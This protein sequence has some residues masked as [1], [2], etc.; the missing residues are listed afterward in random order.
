MRELQFAGYREGPYPSDAVDADFGQGRIR[1]R[2]TANNLFSVPGGDCHALYHHAGSGYFLAVIGDK[3]YRLA[4]GSSTQLVSGITPPAQVVQHGSKLVLVASNKVA[5]INPDDWSVK[6]VNRPSAPSNPSASKFTWQQGD[7]TNVNNAGGATVTVNTYTIGIDDNTTDALGGAWAEL[8]RTDA[9][10]DYVAYLVL[11][12]VGVDA[13][14]QGGNIT[15]INDTSNNEVKAMSATTACSKEGRLVI[16]VNGKNLK[17]VR[18]WVDRG[19]MRIGRYW[20]LVPDWKP[21]AYRITTVDS[22][23]WESEY[24]EVTV[25]GTAENED[26]GW[27]VQLSNLG[28]GTKRIYRQDALG[29]WR[30][31]A[32]TT[33]TSFTD[34]VPEEQIGVRLADIP[35]PV[36]GNCAISWKSRLCVASGNE[37]Y[38][39]APAQFSFSTFDGG[40]K[41]TF[42]SSI[43]SLVDAGDVLYVGAED[44]WYE[45]GGLPGAWMVRYSGMH[46]PANGYSSRLPIVN[47]GR[48]LLVAS[49]PIA[50][51]RYVV[52]TASAGEY[53][54]V[55]TNSEWLVYAGG[56]WARWLLPITFITPVASQG[57]DASFA[58]VDGGYLKTI[59][60]PSSNREAFTLSQKF[61]LDERAQLHWLHVDGSGT[62][63][64]YVNGVS[65]ATGNLPITT[66]WK[67]AEA[68][69]LDVQV[70]VAGELY[71]MLVDVERLSVRR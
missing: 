59:S 1:G 10:S 48:T 64:V 13:E 4:S 31:V 16:P 6:V 42:P 27:Y 71:R 69:V 30:L 19:M 55:V 20:R 60:L 56:R 5:I 22:D 43:K 65:F 70:A 2:P 14:W 54:V 36:G 29:L 12:F 47:A 23:G 44:G 53:T 37:L 9:I 41:L 3:L 15:A 26:L 62:G 39:S 38:V 18:V 40:D 51:D 61:P 68:W 57:N 67:R 46:A 63:S 66:D 7:F 8:Y 33:N 11:E 52:S 28:G 24:K 32:E 45:V 17:G 34:T 50:T 49:K 35:P 25:S 58:F 21:A